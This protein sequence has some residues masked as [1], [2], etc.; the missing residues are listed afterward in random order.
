MKTKLLALLAIVLL[1]F[2]T[3]CGGGTADD[4]TGQYDSYKSGEF[5]E[6]MESGTYYL[7]FTD[8]NMGAEATI[9]MAVDGDESS[10]EVVNLPVRMLT[11]NGNAYYINDQ[12]K[13]ILAVEGPVD[14]ST[15]NPVVFDYSGIKFKTEGNGV[16]SSLSEFDDNVYDYEEFSVGTGENEVLIRYYLKGDDLY[17]IQT[18]MGEVWHTMVINKLTKEIPEGMLIMPAG[19]KVVDAMD[20]YN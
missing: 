11:L 4:E 1:A 9:K 17:V 15:F 20:F 10:V 7:N 19:Y 13:K 8:Y 12:K 3:A 5:V 2:L 14:E 18:N 6:I 16:I